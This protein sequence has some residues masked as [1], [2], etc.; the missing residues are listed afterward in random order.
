MHEKEFTLGWT[1]Y[2][3]ELRLRQGEGWQAVNLKAGD[4]TTD[5]GDR[6]K[7]WRGGQMLELD[8]KGG[9]GQEPIYGQFRWVR[10]E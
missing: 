1:Q 5:K 6:L 9:P 7:G 3:R 4:F 8:S 2:A 10:A